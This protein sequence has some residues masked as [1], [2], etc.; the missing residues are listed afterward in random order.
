MEHLVPHVM[1]SLR[2]AGQP[3]SL[4]LS[5][6]LAPACHLTVWLALSHAPPAL[7]VHDTM[8]EAHAG[9]QYRLVHFCCGA[10]VASAEHVVQ[11]ECAEKSPPY[12]LRAKQAGLTVQNLL[13][14]QRAAPGRRLAVL[15]DPALYLLEEGHSYPSA[16]DAA[17]LSPC[18]TSAVGACCHD[19]LL[20]DLACQDLPA[21]DL[22][23]DLA[24]AVV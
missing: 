4:P 18:W 19:D 16:T 23:V 15:C 2:Y 17:E 9:A 24:T 5:Q 11:W 3:M 20:S 7:A 8:C 12:L 14:C 21:C 6:Q 10:F 13:F 1:A 22:W